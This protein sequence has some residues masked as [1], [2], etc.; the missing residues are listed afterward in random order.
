[1]VEKRMGIWRVEFSD[2]ALQ[3]AAESIVNELHAAGTD[4]GPA[5]LKPHE[6]TYGTPEI[7]I[8]VIVTA[9]AKAVIVAGIRTIQH[10]LEQHL[11]EKADK[12]AQV[13]L[14]SADGEK[15][16]FPISLRGLGRDALKEFT[17]EIIA[18]VGKL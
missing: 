14:E 16:R 7:I 10:V 13:V 17:D 18:A 2:A 5:A 8:T 1:M 15:K 9:A 4:V 3:P 12:R 6:A 11:Q